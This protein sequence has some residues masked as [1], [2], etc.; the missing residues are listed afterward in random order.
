M[1]VAGP[2][3][4]EQPESDDA[5]GDEIDRDDVVEEPRHHEDQNAG[6]ERDDG[7][8]VADAD[9]HGSLRVDRE[10]AK[11]GGCSPLPVGYPSIFEKSATARV[12]ARSALRSLRRFRRKAGSSALT[13]T[14]S[15]KAS[16]GGRRRERA[17]IAPSKSSF[18][19]A[20]RAASPSATS[21]S[22][23]A[24]SSGWRRRWMS[25]AVS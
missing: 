21:A 5:D 2:A 19:T 11:L 6:E 18:A 16:T 20:S 15:K 12:A 23:S 7:L 4:A 9:G 14:L 10:T 17:S 25:G 3:L 8:Q 22:Q 1:S 13:V 24:S